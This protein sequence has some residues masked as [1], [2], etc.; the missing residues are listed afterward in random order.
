[1]NRESTIV[2][3][4]F[5]EV[6]KHLSCSWSVKRGFTKYIKEQLDENVLYDKTITREKLVELLG[7]P[8]KVAE[9]FDMANQNEIRIRAK[10][11]TLSILLTIALIV[12][13]V[14]LVILLVYLYENW[15]GKI[16]Y[17]D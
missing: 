6:R 12:I 16:I 4:Y 8:E 1:M 10:A 17:I 15:G 2:K 9:G 14:L 13:A 7:E 3:K 11:Y 5:K